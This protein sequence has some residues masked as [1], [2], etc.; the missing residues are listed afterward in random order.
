MDHWFC[1]AIA[2]LL[3]LDPVPM[4]YQN[5]LSKLHLIY[6]LCHT[7]NQWSNTGGVIHVENVLELLYTWGKQYQLVLQPTA[8]GRVWQSMMSFV[9]MEVKNYSSAINKNN[10]MYLFLSTMHHQPAAPLGARVNTEAD[11]PSRKDGYS[12]IR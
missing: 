12:L 4:K 9:H 8:H 2:I 1:F 11:T 10:K 7:S 3:F 5:T 6:I